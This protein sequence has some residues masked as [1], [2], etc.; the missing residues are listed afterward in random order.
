MLVHS[1]AGESV[2]TLLEALY[3]YIIK[4]ILK[5]IGTVMAHGYRNYIVNKLRMHVENTRYLLQA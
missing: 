3:V 5:F 1:V 2:R 4:N